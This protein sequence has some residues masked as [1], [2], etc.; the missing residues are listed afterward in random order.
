MNAT[1]NLDLIVFHLVRTSAAQ[2]YGSRRTV[3]SFFQSDHDI[4]FDV[5][6]TFGSRLTSAESTESRSAATAAE[7][8][9]EEVA[10]SSSAK[11]ELD[12]AVTAPLVKS[13]FG[14]L[15]PPSPRRLKSARPV[16][17]R[18]KLI[19]LLSLLRIA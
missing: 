7:E 10:E 18:A 8:R 9:F 17:I 15:C 5:G 13:A 2:R 6:P 1:R 19:V 14:W 16:P 12:P 11:F 4:G 3:E